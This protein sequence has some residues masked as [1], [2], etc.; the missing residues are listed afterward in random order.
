[1]PELKKDMTV[2]QA[3]EMILTTGG[4]YTDMGRMRHLLKLLPR[5]PRCRICNAPFEGL[6]GALVKLFMGK[7]PAR[8]NPLIC[9]AC[10]VFASKYPGGAEIELAMLFADIRGSTALA[11]KLGSREFSKLID[12]F[13]RVSTDVLVHSDGL[14][15]KLIGDEVAALYVSGFAGPLYTQRAVQAA[16]RL[17]AATGHGSSTGPWVPVGVGV[18][19]GKAFVGAVGTKDGI[20][21]FTALGD[22]V[23]A[24]ARLASLAGTGEILVT[25][26]AILKAHLQSDGHERRLL[27]LKGRNASMAVRVLHADD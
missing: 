4:E 5:N 8:V 16:R 20:V 23:N 21:D 17:L 24:T 10:E 12:R 6:G 25:E 26:E 7:Q 11:E 1:M 15:E 19:H 13:F 14:I 27:E 9:N 18:H 3:W 22:A 2:E